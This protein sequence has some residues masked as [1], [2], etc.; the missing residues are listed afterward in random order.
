MMKNIGQMMKQMQE[1][2]EKIAKNQ[3]DLAARR[4]EGS[5]GG[6]VVTMIVDG[7][8][9]LKEV[10]IDP[11]LMVMEEKE[12]LQDL[13]VAAFTDAKNKADKEAATSLENIT[14]GLNLPA[15]FKLPF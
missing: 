15:G 9:N 11:S 4:V 2:Q 12:I 6:G 10:K 1:M 13:L 3:E 8:G 5:A 7:K 14:G